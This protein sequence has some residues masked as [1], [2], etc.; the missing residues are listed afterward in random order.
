MIA[1]DGERERERELG[2]SVR[3]ALPEEGYI[4]I[5]IYRERERERKRERERENL[6]ARGVANILIVSPADE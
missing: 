6:P 4:Y 1:T 2:K 3:A 5:Y